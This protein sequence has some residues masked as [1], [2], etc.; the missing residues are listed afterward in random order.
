[1]G[2]S[3]T[4][5]IEAKLITQVYRT[6]SK[7]LVPSLDS[8]SISA[9]PSEFVTIVGPSGCGKST[10]LKIL[11]GLLRPTSGEVLLH[12][13]PVTEPSREVG[14][15]FQ[16]PILLPWRTVTQN[17]LLPAQIRGER[18]RYQETAAQLL[19]LVGLDG[20]ER[21][22]PRELSGG[23]QQRV[24][25]VRALLTDPQILLMDEPFGA[26]DAMTREQINVDI[27]TIWQ[28]A[29]KTFMLVT[30]SI[31]EAVFLGDRVLV[32]TPR[33]GRIVMEIAVTLPRPR[34]LEV[35]ATP[36]FGEI[37]NTVRSA[38]DRPTHTTIDEGAVHAVF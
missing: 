20:F 9:E 5:A 33:P 3:G 31:S 19:K 15:A 23:M 29:R 37:V 21:K 12:G 6:R 7:E 13:E 38:L 36:E 30:H 18:R 34:T 35:M 22:Y 10:L 14:M 2:S 1:M 28:A 24:A 8:V 17:V 32:M 27:Q 25:I 16:A 26:L 4:P 11:A